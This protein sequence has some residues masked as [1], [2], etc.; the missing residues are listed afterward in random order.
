M[1]FDWK[2]GAPR[3]E[4]LWESFTESELASVRAGDLLEIAEKGGEFSVELSPFVLRSRMRSYESLVRD[5]AD[6]WRSVGYY[7]I[8]EYVNDL[9]SRD[10]ITRACNR[11]EPFL[12]ARIRA[13]VEELDESLWSATEPDDQRRILGHTCPESGEWAAG[14]WWRRVPRVI[15][16]PH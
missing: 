2:T 1:A 5:A 14:W 11:L 10:A 8:D 3:T 7:L 6:E 16:W 13:V 9:S 12:G 15:P 4:A